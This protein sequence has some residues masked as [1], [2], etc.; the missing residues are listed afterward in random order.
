MKNSMDNNRY[1]RPTKDNVNVGDVLVQV[2]DNE[3]RYLQI[4]GK[5]DYSI[6]AKSSEEKPIF[7]TQCPFKWFSEVIVIKEDLLLVGENVGDAL[8]NN[9]TKKL[10][11]AL[12]E[13]IDTHKKRLDENGIDSYSLWFSTNWINYKHSFYVQFLQL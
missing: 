8:I 10:R 13:I 2:M 1:Q 7:I 11:G 12:F 6:T 4:T 9:V 5:S 3:P